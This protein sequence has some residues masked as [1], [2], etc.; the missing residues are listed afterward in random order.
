M[1]FDALPDLTTAEG[2][3]ILAELARD[4]QPEGEPSPL[5][6]LWEEDILVPRIPADLPA[7][8]CAIRLLPTGTCRRA[9]RA[10]SS[11]RL[12]TLDLDFDPDL[13][14]KGLAATAHALHDARPDP[15]DVLAVW[16]LAFQRECYSG[17]YAQSLKFRTWRDADRGL[18]RAA[19]AADDR[20]EARDWFWGWHHRMTGV[21]PTLPRLEEIDPCVALL[22]PPRD[23]RATA[24][25]LRAA[26][27]ATCDEWRLVRFVADDLAALP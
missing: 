24:V 6:T 1:S 7:G 13:N 10:S 12:H 8:A 23:L 16:T 26:A 20:L 18:R 3:A 27:R 15:L 25:L 22:P 5:E 21:I 17:V 14:R 11:Y 19:Q 4:W 2:D 9:R